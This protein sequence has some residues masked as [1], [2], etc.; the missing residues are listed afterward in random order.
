ML[1]GKILLIGAAADT[2]QSLS[3]LL[4]GA[5]YQPVAAAGGSAALDAAVFHRPDLILL[6]PDLPETDGNGMLRSLRKWYG[7]PVLVLS[8]Q[9]G[10]AEKIRALDLGA[11]DYITKPFSQGE[12][13]ARIR[14]ALRGKLRA[15]A[16]LPAAPSSYTVGELTIDFHRRLVTV[17]G[18]PVH[19][20]QNEFRIVELLAW[21]PGQV[22]PY[23]YLMGQIW[24]P[25][26]P[27]GNKILRVNMTHIRK[28]LEK[29]PG[30]PRYF[31]TE[32]GVG[33][34]ISTDSDAALHI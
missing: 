34:R 19:L 4:T 21:R 6:D 23:G 7:N 11:D 14:A 30:N 9:T 31:L 27:K 1:T 33:Y 28:K 15:E 5:G 16:G 2:F 29:D 25:Y 20:T 26:L 10:E 32:T 22:I 8:E 24:G 17:A 13:L 3:R 12:L 18:K